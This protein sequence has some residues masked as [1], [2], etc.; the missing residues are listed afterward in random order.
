MSSELETAER[1]VASLEAR[2]AAL[3]IQN[4]SPVPASGSE[5]TDAAVKAYQVQLLARLVEVRDSISQQGG[6]AVAIAAE[7][8]AAL[9]ENKQLKK[10][11]AK[12]QY[13]VKHLIRSLDEEEKRNSGK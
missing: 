6:D 5:N 8:D 12:L 7:R 3:E 11:I 9:L 4:Q 10:E 1:K 2:L 13:R